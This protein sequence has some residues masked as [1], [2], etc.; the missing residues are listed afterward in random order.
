MP[1]EKRNLLYFLAFEAADAFGK[2]KLE[3]L[4]REVDILFARQPPVVS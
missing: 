1:F 3:L 2:R 4:N